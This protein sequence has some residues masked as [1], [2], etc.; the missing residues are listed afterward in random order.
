MFML[1]SLALGYAGTWGLAV[2]A[3]ETALH[4]RT[5][6]NDKMITDQGKQ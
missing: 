2:R 3:D 1:M 6:V 5:K 4:R